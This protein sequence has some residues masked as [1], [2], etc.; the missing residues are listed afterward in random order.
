[1]GRTFLILALVFLAPLTASPESADHKL[2][3]IV[4]PGNPVEKL[5]HAELKRLFRAERKHWPDGRPVVL[6]MRE[7]FC[8][9]RDLLLDKVYGMD[10][11]HYRRFWLEKV[12]RGEAN[13]PQT[14]MSAEAMKEIVGRQKGALG[15]L[16]EDQADASVKILAIDGKREIAQGHDVAPSGGGE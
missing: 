10:E 13:R 1:M 4:H 2:V 5:S 16:W 15:Y 6:V 11:T 14:A 3:I 7:A 9:E 12:F 8:K